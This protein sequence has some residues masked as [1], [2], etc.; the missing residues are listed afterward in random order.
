MA[1]PLLAGQPAHRI[2]HVMRGQSLLFVDGKHAFDHDH[3]PKTTATITNVELRSANAT[4]ILAFCYG[5]L[6]FAT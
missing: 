1:D 3:G 4:P 5:F 6:L 2:D